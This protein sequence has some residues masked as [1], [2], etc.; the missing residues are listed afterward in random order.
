MN[1]VP[2]HFETTSSFFLNSMFS[3]FIWKTTS[4]S[5]P[6][7]IIAQISRCS[8]NKI[9]NSVQENFLQATSRFETSTMA[10]TGNALRRNK[11]S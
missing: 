6:D 7:I 4:L 9:G 8:F 2:R 10:V 11:K 3:L 5:G 1:R